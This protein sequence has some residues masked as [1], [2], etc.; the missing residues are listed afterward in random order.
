MQNAMVVSADA[1]EA[2]AYGG[3]GGGGRA[4]NIIIGEDTMH[5]KLWVAPDRERCCK[6]GT[7]LCVITTHG[8]IEEERPIGE[9][10]LT[11]KLM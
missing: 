1:C 5:R 2:K 11:K 9:C 4:C 3:C 10:R 6:G 8:G 7:T